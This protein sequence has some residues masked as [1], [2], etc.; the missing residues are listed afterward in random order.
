[1]KMP[2]PA[3]TPWLLKKV[4]PSLTWH[5]PEKARAVYL[6]FDDGPTPGVTDWVL[7]EL[8]TYE[9]RA[10]FFC[11]GKNVVQHPKLYQKILEA[12]HRAGTIPSTISTDGSTTPRPIYPIP[13]KPPG[14]LILL[15]FAL[16][17]ENCVTDK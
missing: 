9:A 16:L 4:Y 5:I 15:F 3:S 12:G 17:M 2:V 11:I 8:Q 14:L 6:T 13:K 1:M 7:K 10:T